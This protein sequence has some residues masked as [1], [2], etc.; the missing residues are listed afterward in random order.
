M[1]YTFLKIRAIAKVVVT[2]LF[3]R[4]SVS[5]FINEDVAKDSLTSPHKEFSTGPPSIFDT[6]FTTFVFLGVLFLWL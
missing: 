2:K 4:T 3:R 6:S 1:R 5:Y